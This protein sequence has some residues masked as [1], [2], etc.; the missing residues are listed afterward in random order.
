VILVL[1]CTNGVGNLPPLE[2]IGEKAK[3]N[4]SKLI[5]EPIASG[6]VP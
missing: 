2:N 4:E 5:K 6:D 3:I 1:S